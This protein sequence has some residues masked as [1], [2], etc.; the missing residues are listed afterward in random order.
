VI[1][2]MRDLRREQL[3]TIR[4]LASK[5]G[6]STRTVLRVEQGAQVPHPGTIKKLSAALGVEPA[7]VREFRLVMG[8]VTE[9]RG[10]S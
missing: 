1:R 6:V 4:G 8:L 9:E 3:Q 7:Q 5:A 2:P 10:V